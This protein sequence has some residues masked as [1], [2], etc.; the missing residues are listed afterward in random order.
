MRGFGGSTPKRRGSSRLS[1]SARSR[2]CAG[3]GYPQ[4]QYHCN[5]RI[6]LAGACKGKRR[7]ALTDIDT[8]RASNPGCG[9]S[10]AKPLTD[11]KCHCLAPSS[12]RRIS[13]DDIY[14]LQTI[15]A[16]TMPFDEPETKYGLRL[17]SQMAKEPSGAIGSCWLDSQ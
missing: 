2:C 9:A 5:S 11:G 16:K 6:P 13:R 3:L 14:V 12:V 7:R 17:S 1:T 8:G 15:L 4:R 10:V